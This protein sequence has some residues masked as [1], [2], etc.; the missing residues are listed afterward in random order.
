[1][2][3]GT[4]R[5]GIPCS[6]RSSFAGEAQVAIESPPLLVPQVKAGK[7]RALA[8]ARPDRSPLLPDVPTLQESGF[9]NFDVYT[10]LAFL[11]PAGL[12]LELDAQ[13]PVRLADRRRHRRGRRDVLARAARHDRRAGQHRRRD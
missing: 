1:M 3:V 13:R 12:A 4:A 8:V 9:K 5:G 11:A 6:A 2:R 7:L 10:W